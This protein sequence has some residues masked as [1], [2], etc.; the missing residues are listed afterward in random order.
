MTTP[1]IQRA[2]ADLKLFVGMNTGLRSTGDHMLKA[3]A[4]LT[5]AA[6]EPPGERYW[7][8]EHLA[9]NEEIERLK[10][11]NETLR[12]ASEPKGEPSCYGAFG[13]DLHEARTALHDS[14]NPNH[15]PTWK[16]P[17]VEPTAEPVA[18][19]LETIREAMRYAGELLPAD[20]AT[21]THLWR[22][23][24]ALRVLEASPPAPTV[25]PVAIYHG[26]CR[27]DC[28]DGGHLDVELLKLIPKGT[29][30][31]TMPG[32]S[33]APEVPLYSTTV[34]P[35]APQGWVSVPVEPTEAMWTA[36][37]DPV[38]YRDLRHY[39]PT[40]EPAPAWQIAPDGEVETD[41]SKGTT[42]VHVWRAMI[43]AVPTAGSSDE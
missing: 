40:D 36:G 31:Y 39:R 7:K 25:E 1:E 5:A 11:E 18:R 30:L 9:G 6:S 8:A 34:S 37:R 29:K 43:A 21:E 20:E 12:A 26:R 2:A 17:T 41:K 23:A 28:G 22:V 3:L 14:R 32:D 16:S 15:E 42:A 4:T 13:D 24:G 19:A 10:R 35:P 38:M 27:L 33:L